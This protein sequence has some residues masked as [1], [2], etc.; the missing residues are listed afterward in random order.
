MSKIKHT[1]SEILP[2]G[3]FEVQATL[4]G[5]LGKAEIHVETLD[6]NIQMTAIST[7]IIWIKPASLA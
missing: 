2:S 7:V 5:L 3:V 6:D 4:H 1:T